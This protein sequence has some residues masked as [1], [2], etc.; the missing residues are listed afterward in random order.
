MRVIIV[1]YIL[2]GIIALIVILLHF[3]IRA[4]VKL[5][6][7]G[8]KLEVKYLFFTVFKLPQ[9]PEKKKKKKSKKPK[10]KKLKKNK[11]TKHIEVSDTP[12]S[13]NEIDELKKQLDEDAEASDEEIIIEE[14][15]PEPPPKPLTK[16]EQKA[17]KKKQK[18]EKK[19][20]KAEKKRLKAEE[21]ANKTPLKEKL[22]DL[23]RKWLMIKPYIPVGWKAVKKLLKA[24]RFRKT[25]IQLGF[26]KED[27][28]EAA[29]NYGKMN[30]AVYDGLA[31][32]G[33]I[34]TMHYKQVKIYCLFNEKA[35]KYDLETTVYVRP[36]T[37]I[38]IAFCTLVNFLKIFI[39]Q[40]LKKRKERKAMEKAKKKTEKLKS[41][42]TETEC[43]ENERK[44]AS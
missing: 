39:S 32:L 8:F 40:K 33:H 23:K 19:K 41:K 24:I 43:I 17:L 36:S 44:Q 35:T 28:Y 14:K 5:D 29:M 12:L 38:A 4:H 21:K 18:E 11:K 3:S 6:A 26:G 1:L 20:A 2:L 31:V 27:P 22:A 34:F 37:I 13:E 7:D 10:K 25:S 9:D 30:I 16:A 15:K 42:N